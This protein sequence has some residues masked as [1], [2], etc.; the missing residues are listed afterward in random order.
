MAGY[1]GVEIMGSEGYLINQFIAEHTNHRQDEWGGSYE[2]RIRFPLEIIR[3]VREAV[4]KNFIIIYRLSM[5]DLIE[6]GSS[7]SEIVTLAQAVED[8]GATL[9]NTGIGWHEARIPTIATMVP[10]AAFTSITGH[11]KPEVTIPVITSNRINTPELA[12]HL[13]WQETEK[14]KAP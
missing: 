14:T 3:S 13:R 7:W 1:D 4:G 12:E 9:I 8:A 6:K 5:L 2:N 11:L 10:K